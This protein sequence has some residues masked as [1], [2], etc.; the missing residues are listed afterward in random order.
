M[1]ENL[2]VKTNRKFAEILAK[3]TVTYHGHSKRRRYIAMY[4]PM[5][6]TAKLLQPCLPYI[7]ADEVMAILMACIT[8]EI[9]K[10]SY[11]KWPIDGR[12]GRSDYGRLGVGTPQFLTGTFTSG[13][14]RGPS[15]VFQAP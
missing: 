1:K 12:N 13:S 5:L 6:G 10:N 7:C 11:A 3:V 15:V 4:Q 2:T 8:T 9:I 14:A